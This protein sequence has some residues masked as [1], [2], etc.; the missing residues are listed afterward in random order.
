ML[1]HGDCLEV[2]KSIE[3]GSIDMV[4]TDPPYGTTQNKWDTAINPIEIHENAERVLRNGGKMVLFSQ[5]P[6]TTEL[7]TNGINN[8]KFSY[9]AMWLKD[10]FA[11]ALGCNVNMVMFTEDI[12]IFSKNVEDKTGHPMQEY[13]CGEFDRIGKPVKWYVEQLGTS[14]ASHFFTKGKQFRIPNEKYLQQLKDITGGY[15][16]EFEEV[17]TAQKEFLKQK[18]VRN[19]STF[20]LWEGNKY[21]SNVL[22]YP[23]DKERFHTTQ[24]PVALLEDLIQTFSDKSDTVLDMTMGSGS[25][26]VACVNTNRKFI[27]IELDENYFNIAKERIENHL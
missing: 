15:C 4:L 3:S 17:E 24:K 12:L 11:N 16:I 19:R 27:G 26:G 10:G 21:K 25:T 1:H 22:S 6:Y 7:I 2:M 23:R 20:N 13:F 5:E 14:H 8:I 9:R 18:R